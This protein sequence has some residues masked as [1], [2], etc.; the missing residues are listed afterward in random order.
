[1]GSSCKAELKSTKECGTNTSLCLHQANYD[2]A[3]TPNPNAPYY[4][5]YATNSHSSSFVYPSWQTYLSGMSDYHY[6]YKAHGF[7]TGLNPPSYEIGFLSSSPN[8]VSLR[9][10]K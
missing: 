1:M 8:M 9:W 4:P 7:K 10:T 5:R 6:Q 3:S 2:Q